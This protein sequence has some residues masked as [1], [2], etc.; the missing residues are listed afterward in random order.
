MKKFSGESYRSGH[1]SF[2]ILAVF[3]C[4]LSLV[5]VNSYSSTLISY[6]SVFYKSPDI[7]SFETLA[8]NSETKLLTLKGT[9]LETDVLVITKRQLHFTFK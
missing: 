4:I 1:R 7:K 3:W 8:A 2:G 5:I 9:F 6:L